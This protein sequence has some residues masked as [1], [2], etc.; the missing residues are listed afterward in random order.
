MNVLYTRQTGTQ[1]TKTHAKKRWIFIIVGLLLLIAVVVTLLELTNTTYLFHKRPP[2]P[3]ASSETKGETVS[4]SQ[5][6]Q[7]SNTSPNPSVN[8]TDNNNPK[9]GNNTSNTTLVMFPSDLVSAH[10]V[11][12]DSAIASTCNATAGA[13]C[14]IT[15]SNGGISKSLPATITDRGGSAYWN[16]WKPSDIGLT[17]GTWK[18]EAIATLGDQ[19]KTQTDALN[20]EVSQ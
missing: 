13:S 7:T 2:A 4:P 6:G 12:L 19:R 9:A 5:T 11:Q 20:L 10:K 8:P 1:T 15:F 16:S 3:T 14:L 17:P 18:I